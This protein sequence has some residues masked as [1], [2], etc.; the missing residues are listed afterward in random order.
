MKKN[1]Y[2]FI[3]WFQLLKMQ[4]QSKGLNWWVTDETVEPPFR[5]FGWTQPWVIW[6]ML[7]LRQLPEVLY[8]LNFSVILKL[9][10]LTSIPKCNFLLIIEKLQSLCIFWICCSLWIQL[11][12][13]CL[14]SIKPEKKSYLWQCFEG[15]SLL[16]R[17]CF[18]RLSGQTSL[19][20]AETKWTA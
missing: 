20:R 8:N 7:T 17:N 11:F 14:C 9:L 6:S 10:F 19:R 13:W 15:F 3:V 1:H 18:M 5:E 12:L 16:K 4:I 2:Q